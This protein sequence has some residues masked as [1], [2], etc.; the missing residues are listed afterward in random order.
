LGGSSFGGTVTVSV[1]GNQVNSQNVSDSPSTISFNYK[2]TS[3]GPA[4]ITATVT[5]SVL[6]QAT[7]SAQTTM[8]L[9]ASSPSNNGNG[10]GNGGGQGA[11]APRQSPLANT[12]RGAL[13]GQAG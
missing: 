13:T 4:T 5:D 1:N 2:P 7:Q 3:G 8:S 10:N 12:R 11:T 9:S 6:Y